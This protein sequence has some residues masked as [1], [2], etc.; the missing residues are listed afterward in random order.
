[1][2]GLEQEYKSATAPSLRPASGMVHRP[3]H[4]HHP[5]KLLSTSTL[6]AAHAIT[7][8]SHQVDKSFDN[9]R[10]HNT[11]N[12]D[13]AVRHL[14]IRLPKTLDQLGNIAFE[15][16]LGFVEEC[17]ESKLRESQASSNS[18]VLTDQ[19]RTMQ[20]EMND[21]SRQ[22][23]QLREL[24][25][26]ECLHSSKIS[27]R[28][29]EAMDRID[30]QREE[31]GRAENIDQT[32]E[33]ANRTKLNQEDEKIANGGTVI[34]AQEVSQATQRV[35]HAQKVDQIFT[36]VT[37]EVT[38]LLSAD[39]ATLFLVD[40]E[41]NQLWSRVASGSDPIRIPMNAGIVGQCVSTKKSLRIDD[42]YACQFFNQDVDKQTGY[43]TTSVLAV[44]VRSDQGEVLGALQLINKD[45]SKDDGL[46]SS[47]DEDVLRSFCDHIAIAVQQC[48]TMESSKMNMI[49]SEKEIEKLRIKMES[50]EKM[51]KLTRSLLSQQ[52]LS[53]VFESVMADVRELLG[54]DRATLFVLDA[55]KREM[56]SQVAHG[57]TEEIRFPM[58]KGLVG[59]A[60]LSKSI[61]NVKDAYEDVRFNKAIDTKTGY[62]TQSVL[63]IAVTGANNELVGV[64]QAINKF[65]EHR[66]TCAFTPSDET[67]AVSFCAQI[68]VA[69]TNATTAE[70]SA[71]L[72]RTKVLLLRDL[73]QQHSSLVQVAQQQQRDLSCLSTA[74]TTVST[75]G[76]L[77][78]LLSSLDETFNVTM[79]VE[80]CIVVVCDADLSCTVRGFVFGDVWSCCCSL[81][82]SL[83]H[84]VKLFSAD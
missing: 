47:N 12:I 45:V 74:L 17:K 67:M 29:N 69:V 36:T 1:M 49:Q 64:V 82:F 50:S 63:C 55:E 34:S 43:K 18:V 37:S 13:A 62:R 8:I 57:T 68:A 3:P 41:K 70:A 27:T 30:R 83:C 10:K 56:F 59:A 38:T 35:L 80:T 81:C 9:M 19:L 40:K 42:A 2:S 77:A 7:S 28:L 25:D 51:R 52:E 84:F 75:P 78:N 71:S 65:D 58:D 24:F 11:M 23:Q 5:L 22:N 20:A 31:K 33:A 4:A 66:G 46:F 53:S 60:A 16:V 79:G 15:K 21:I 73:E 26:N 39:R 44:P 61:V 54:C 76:S 14:R 6:K 32:Q 72:L 48:N